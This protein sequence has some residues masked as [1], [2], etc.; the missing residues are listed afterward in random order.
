MTLLLVPACNSPT[1]TLSRAYP[2]IT[3]RTYLTDIYVVLADHLITLLPHPLLPSN[4]KML[5]F[6]TSAYHHHALSFEKAQARLN[7]KSFGPNW[8]SSFFPC[9]PPYYCFE[10]A[11]L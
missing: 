11:L 4:T 3:M 1:Q 10:K 7:S 2:S 6:R 8:G 9:P 5:F